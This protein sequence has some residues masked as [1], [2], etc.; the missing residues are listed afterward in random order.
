MGVLLPGKTRLKR[1]E[2]EDMEDMEGMEDIESN[3]SETSST[4]LQRKAS[5]EQ[6][7]YRKVQDQISN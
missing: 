7:S 1:V 2:H 6:I 5:L 3:N 4:L